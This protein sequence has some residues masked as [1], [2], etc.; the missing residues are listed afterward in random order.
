[1]QVFIN[2]NFMSFFKICINR[3]SLEPFLKCVEPQ[4]RECGD[5]G[6]RGRGSCGYVGVHVPLILS[7]GIAAPCGAVPSALAPRSGPRLEGASR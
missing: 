6:D 1:M 2:L 3:F 5:V 7:L 4:W